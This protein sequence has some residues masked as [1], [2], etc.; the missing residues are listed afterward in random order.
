MSEN[1]CKIIYH[2]AIAIRKHFAPYNINLPARY[3]KM[4]TVKECRVIKFFWK[5]VEKVCV[6]I[7][8]KWLKADSY[9]TAYEPIA[10]TGSGCR[11]SSSVCG[12]Y[13]SGRMSK[14][15]ETG[16]VVSAP[17]QRSETMRI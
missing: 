1:F 3:I 17:S 11:S 7:G 12:G 13:L 10:E 14:R 2:K 9:N 6:W 16:K 15:K 8:L 4:K 5:S